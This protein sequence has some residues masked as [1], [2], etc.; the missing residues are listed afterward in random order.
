MQRRAKFVAEIRE[1]VG[2][3][4]ADLFGSNACFDERL[5]GAAALGDV[6]HERNDRR[7]F[8]ECNGTESNGDRNPSSI[9]VQHIQFDRFLNEL[10]LQN[11]VQI[12]KIR[13]CSSS[14]TNF[15]AGSSST[16]FALRLL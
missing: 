13:G 7:L 5:L 6:R 10:A 15:V 9:L 8:I 12:S 16:S 11:R 1:D 4:V 2:L 3:D 14:G